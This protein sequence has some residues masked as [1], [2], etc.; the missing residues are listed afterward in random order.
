MFALEIASSKT[1][2]RMLRSS[3]TNGCVLCTRD[4]VLQLSVPFLMRK[5]VSLRSAASF[6]S[7]APSRHRQGA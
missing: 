2:T 4:S 1:I 7:V 6:Q 3:L 5:Y